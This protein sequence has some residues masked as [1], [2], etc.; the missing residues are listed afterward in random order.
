MFNK[1][2]IAHDGE[3][4]PKRYTPSTTRF[5]NF[6]TV[7][8]QTNGA[9]LLKPEA[10]TLAKRIKGSMATAGI[11]SQSD[12]ARRVRVNRQLVHK[13]VSG[14]VDELTPTLLFRLADVL[15]VSARWLALGPP[16]SPTK[17]RQ[18]SIDEVELLDIA[19]ALKQRDREAWISSGRAMVRLTAEASAGNPFPLRRKQ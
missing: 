17:S 13:W 8:H 9:A 4:S 12:L 5:A 11:E 18:M 2:G 19:S 7:Q 3:L 15:K 6:V 16:I 1:V 10:I 14:Q